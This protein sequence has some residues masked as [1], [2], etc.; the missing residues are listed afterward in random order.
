VAIAAVV[1]GAFDPA[2]VAAAA[3][4]GLV[5]TAMIVRRDGDGWHL[6]AVLLILAALGEILTPILQRFVVSP[7]AGEGK[8]LERLLGVVDGTAVVVVRRA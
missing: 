8:P 3:A 1:N 7:V 4:A 5:V 2:T 6:F